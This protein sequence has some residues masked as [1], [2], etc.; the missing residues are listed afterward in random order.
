MKVLICCSKHFYGEIPPIKS[1]LELLRHEVHLPNSFESPMKEEEMK[2]K[3]AEDHRAWKARMIRA[4][5][6]KVD[7]ADAV[8]VLNYE[9]NGQSNY[10]GGAT[11]LEVYKAFEKRKEIY[12][13]NPLPKNIFHDELLAFGCTVINGDLSLISNEHHI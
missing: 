5:D 8:L 2:R 12:V 4:H 9:K 11:F 10:I 1:Q 13:W 6:T 3:S 7:A